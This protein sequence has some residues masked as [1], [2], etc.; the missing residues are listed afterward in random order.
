[1]Q[2]SEDIQ[3]ED[4]LSAAYDDIVAMASEV[5][6]DGHQLLQALPAPGYLITG[7]Q[8]PVLHERYRHNCHV[9]FHINQTQRGMRWPLLR[10]HTFKDGG[11]V[12]TFNGFHW[13][14]Q[15]NRV[16]AASRTISIRP[17]A[18]LVEERKQRD[19]H[20]TRRHSQ[21]RHR[22][23]YSKPL[24]VIHPWLV[25]RLC[26]HATPELIARTSIRLDGQHLLAPLVHD[27][28]TDTGFHSVK[29]SGT[30]NTKR[31]YI[32]RAG[33]LK[34]SYVVIKQA[35]RTHGQS[36]T[37]IL[38]CEGLAT[39]LSLALVC[40]TEIRI[41]LY[42]YNIALLREKIQSPVTI[43]CDNDQWK[44]HAGNVG[45][46]KA[47]EALKKGDTLLCPEFSAQSLIHQPTDF[48]DLLVHEGISQLHQQLNAGALLSHD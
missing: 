22:Y 40:Q 10:F 2:Y 23:S 12:R 33:L 42:A 11:N 36:A 15:N 18:Q 34:G 32:R 7:R 27:S 35:Q 8:V 41:A 37:P 4:V 45:L 14:K 24:D 21:L 47:R 25:K 1:M 46:H 43:C 28:H 17:N 29:L 20:R 44:P 38:I 6:I 19:Y 39:G 16:P 9:L 5:G 13:L 26:G 31:H 3:P 48:N 30:T